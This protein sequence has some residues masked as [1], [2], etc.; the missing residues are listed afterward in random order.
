MSLKATDSVKNNTGHK[1][2][3][4]YVFCTFI[5]IAERCFNHIVSTKYIECVLS[6]LLG[7]SA[8]EKW[9]M[10]S[11]S[12]ST[13]AEQPAAP[14]DRDAA[15]SQ[16]HTHS[17]HQNSLTLTIRITD[18]ITPTSWAVKRTYTHSPTP[19]YTVISAGCCCAV[20]VRTQMALTPKC[21]VEMFSKRITDS[22]NVLMW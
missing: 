16:C 17:S 3:V 13:E 18:C 11:F 10:S 7:A 22:D 1:M 12:R 15:C 6:F 19:T 9:K 2:L 8:P 4:S 21:S 20:F 5:F 14:Q